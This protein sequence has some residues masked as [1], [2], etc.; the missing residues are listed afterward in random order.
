MLRATGRHEG[1]QGRL[2]DDA[3]EGHNCDNVGNRVQFMIN[4]SF[5]KI[6]CF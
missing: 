6:D 4:L 3:A 1:A 5:N 2:L